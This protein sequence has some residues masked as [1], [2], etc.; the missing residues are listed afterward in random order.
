[1]SKWPYNTST[2]RRLRKAKL[3]D[4]PLCEACLRREIVEP[5]DTVDHIVAIEKGGDPF[6]PLD[7]LMSM[8]AACH[9]I[10]TNAVDHPNASGFRRALKGFDVNG[11]PIDPEGWDAPAGRA[12]AL[13][14]DDEAGAFAGLGSTGAGPARESRIDLVSCDSFAT[15]DREA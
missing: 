7:Q 13:C 10:K 11:N 1:M 3:V 4:Q 6:P 5:A 12:V 15:R 8:C 2:W 9:N 14:G